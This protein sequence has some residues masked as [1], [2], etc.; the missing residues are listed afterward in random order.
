M[1]LV[2]IDICSRMIVFLHMFFYKLQL[3]IYHLLISMIIAT[4]PGYNA[5]SIIIMIINP[6][7]AKAKARKFQIEDFKY[8]SLC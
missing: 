5:M 3:E 1:A 6:V 2:Y 4:A 8:Q 7:S